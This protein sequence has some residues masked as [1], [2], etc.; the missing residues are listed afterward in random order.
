VDGREIGRRRSSRATSASPVATRRMGGRVLD[1]PPSPGLDWNKETGE[2][3]A[4]LAVKHGYKFI[5][6][7]N[8]A[9]PVHGLWKDIGC[10]GA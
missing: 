5:C 10:T 8:F 4:E 3:C 2:V 6:T 1:G 9:L 7:S